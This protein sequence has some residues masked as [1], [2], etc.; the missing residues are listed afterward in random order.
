M[1]LSVC[2]VYETLREEQASPRAKIQLIRY[3]EKGDLASTPFLKDLVS[4][5]LMCGSCTANCPAGVDLYGKFMEMRRKMVRN[6]GERVEIRSLIYLLPREYRLTM[7]SRLADIGLRL[8]PQAFMKKYAL[9]PLGLKSLPRPNPRP[10]RK[11]VGESIS[12]ATAPVGKVIY[13]TGCGTNYLYEDTGHAVVKLLSHLG[14]QV[15]IPKDQGCCAIPMLFH[16]AINQAMDPIKKNISA[17][18]RDDIDSVIVDCATCATAL[19]NEYPDLLEDQGAVHLA[20]QRISAKTTHIIPF[21]AQHLGRL[22][23]TRRPETPIKATYHAPCHLKNHFL[24]LAKV[25]E[26][27]RKLPFIDYIHATDADQCCGGGGTFF[28]EFPDISRKMVTKK[29]ANAAATQADWWMT[30]CPVCRIQ[31]ASRLTDEDKI[32]VVHPVTLIAPAV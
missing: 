1:C 15:I 19:K 31:L 29:I 5:C 4:R 20:A 21:I 24:P 32:K 10:F 7:G 11:A 30:D 28:Y 17:L 18:D 23:F 16:G 2:P 22:T 8:L 9:E 3:F 6:H 27:F 14:Y 26:L 12:P 25:E 13:F